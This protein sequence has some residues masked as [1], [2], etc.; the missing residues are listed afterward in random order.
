MDEEAATDPVVVDPIEPPLQPV[1]PA[2]PAQPVVI[3]PSMP[4]VQPVAIAQP[5]VAAPPVVVPNLVNPVAHS[6]V[7]K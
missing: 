5:V 1:A 3:H 7:D 4:T 2:E 6:F